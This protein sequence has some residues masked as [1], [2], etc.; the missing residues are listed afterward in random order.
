MVNSDQDSTEL[1]DTLV[2]PEEFSIASCVEHYQLLADRIEAGGDICL[3][4]GALNRIDAAG[5]QLLLVVQQTLKETGHTLCWGEV[6][7]ALTGAA[8]LLGLTDSLA[9]PAAG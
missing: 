6:S 8:D 7:D 4:G 3:D 5:L 9:L 2:L 1:E